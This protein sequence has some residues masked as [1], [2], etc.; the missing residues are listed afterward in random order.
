MFLKLILILILINPFI[1]KAEVCKFKKYKNGVNHYIT[2]N[3]LKIQSTVEVNLISSDREFLFD[4]YEEA[5][6]LAFLNI[7]KFLKFMNKNEENN[8]DL[9]FKIFFKGKNKLSPNRKFKE[10][11]INQQYSTDSALKGIKLLYRCHIPKEL[12]RVTVEVST[13]S[14]KDAEK[15]QSDLDQLE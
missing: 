14:I 11:F 6:D 5:E 12:V 3:K 7:S 15:L 4:A 13:E 1:A 8:N 10:N 2:R 9:D